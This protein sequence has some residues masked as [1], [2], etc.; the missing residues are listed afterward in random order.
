ML[1]FVKSP[2]NYTGGKFKLLPDIIPLVPVDVNR[3]IEPFG[4]GFNVGINTEADELIYNDLC[5]PVT[6]LLEYFSSHSIEDILSYIDETIEEWGLVKG[7]KVSYIKFRDFF[8]NNS[9]INK[10]PLNLYVLVCFGFN[11]MVRYNKF[12]KFNIPIGVNGFNDSMRSNLVSFVERLGE[13]KISFSSVDYRVLFRELDLN[14]ND[15][16]Y[17]DPP[18]YITD[19]VYNKIWDKR[20]EIQLYKQLDKLNNDNIRFMLSNVTNNSN[21]TNDILVNWLENNNLNVSY[22]SINYD[23][24]DPYNT[25]VKG[26][27]VEVLVRNF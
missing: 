10:L 21:K 2:L 6:E 26:K 25:K 19:A 20:A 16:V 15:L 11:N 4:G 24:F 22:P 12:N 27:T 5:K 23:G 13:Y 1:D 9:R 3:F 7:D 14:N 17:C 18:Y 8:N